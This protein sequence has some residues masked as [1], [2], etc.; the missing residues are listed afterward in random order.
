M[1]IIAVSAKHEDWIVPG[2]ERYQKRLKKPF[3]VEWVLTA[4]S[5]YSGIR[6]SEDESGRILK[7]LKPES[8]V[9]VLDERGK[10]LDSKE[11]SKLILNQVSFGKNIVFVIGGAYGVSRSLIERADFVLSLSSMVFPHQLV[12]LILIEQIYRAQTITSNHPY[13][14]A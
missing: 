9:V 13:H 5:P 1:Q 6:A 8:F 7:L 10:S 11:F 4:N 14:H 3:M 2:L 12:R